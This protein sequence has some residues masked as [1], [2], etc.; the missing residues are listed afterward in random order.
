[1]SSTVLYAYWSFPHNP[2]PLKEHLGDLA[3][4]VVE[5]GADFGIVVD[6]DVDRLAFRMRQAKCLEKNI[7]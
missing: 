1:M 4:A 6:P 2:E 3:K 5:K 7:L